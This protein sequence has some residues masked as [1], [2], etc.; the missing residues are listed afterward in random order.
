MATGTQVLTNGFATDA[1][2]RTWGLVHEN[3]ILGAGL[4]RAAD[5]GQ[6]DWATV[7]KPVGALTDAGYV[8]YRF[9]DALQAT[10]PIHLKVQYGTN[11]TATGGRMQISVGLAGTNG[12]GT[13]IGTAA[14][15]FTSATALEAVGITGPDTFMW[16]G[17]GSRILHYRDNA[18]YPRG[19]FIDRTRDSNDAPNGD[20][21]LF[22][23]K[24]SADTTWQ[25]QFGYYQSL[26]W[27]SQVS[28]ASYVPAMDM[29]NQPGTTGSGNV[30]IGPWVIAYGAEEDSFGVFSWKN[31]DIANL[32]LATTPHLNDGADRAYLPVG[33]C[34]GGP[35]TASRLAFLYE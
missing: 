5:T 28:S 2:F 17:E 6:I 20:G 24:R 8:M 22:I 27:S 11:N 9:N 25:W 10:R 14:R 34:Q 18:S 29:G 31:G 12:A 3:A 19:F 32:V 26:S 35:A 16:A 21:V 7:T 30:A 13:F 4:V 23:H 33:T 1:E 15:E